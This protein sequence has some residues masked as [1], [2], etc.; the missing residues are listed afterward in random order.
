MIRPFDRLNAEPVR[1]VL[2]ARAP[3]F[4]FDGR[5]LG[6]FE[7]QELKK[8][9]VSG[10]P[11]S[12]VCRFTGNALGVPS[13]G[14]DDT[15][16]FATS[17]RATGLLSVKASGGEPRV[18]TKP[19]AG[20]GQL[21]HSS[22]FVLPSGKAILFAA[23]SLGSPID[24]QVGVLDL[25]TGQTKILIRAGSQP[26]YVET[27]H[28]IYTTAGT[29]FAVRFDPVRLEVLSDPVPI[30][31]DLATAFGSRGWPTACPVRARWRICRLDPAGHQIGLLYG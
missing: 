16:V 26:S 13:W 10:G 14:P 3:F 7:G 20:Q 17:D 5:W 23:G 31:E 21:D 18:L 8:M 29:L 6:F 25:E 22:P 4:S 12:L 15:I 11:P 30:V 2:D 28:L 27:G 24:A 19:D 9:A 1:G